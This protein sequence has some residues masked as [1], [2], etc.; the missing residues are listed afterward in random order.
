MQ[1]MFIFGIYLSFSKG[2]ALAIAATVPPPPVAD[3]VARKPL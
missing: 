1:S 2:N 3:N